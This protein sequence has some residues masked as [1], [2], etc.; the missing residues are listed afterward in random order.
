MFNVNEFELLREVFGKS[1]IGVSK[2]SA[3]TPI[4]EAFDEAYAT[5]IADADEKKSVSEIFGVPNQKCV[6]KIRDALGFRCIYFPL[7]ASRKNIIFIGPFYEGERNEAELLASFEKIG[8]KPQSQSFVMKYCRSIPNIR[9]DS[10]L[11]ILL[12][13]FIE[14]TFET[15]DYKIMDFDTHRKTDELVEMKVADDLEGSL[16]YMKMIEKRYKYENELIAAVTEG[17]IEK[18]SQIVSAFKST[19]FEMRSQD[20]IRNIKNYS[21]IMNTLLRKAAEQG[22][23]HPVYIDKTSGNFAVAIEG[24]KTAEGCADLMRQMFEK[25]CRLVKNHSLKGYSPLAQ[26]AISVIECDLSAD[27]SPSNIAAAAGVSLPYLC[28]VFKKETGKTLGDFIKDR[29]MA[30]AAKLLKET[31]LLVQT[32]ASYVGFEDVQYFS[33]T[34]KKHTGKTPLEYRREYAWQEKKR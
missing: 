31:A 5:V 15:P 9:Q 12:Y 34:F 23:V 10:E 17:R 19:N 16:L 21:I 6:Y 24:V 14:R 1:G 32:V 3:D 2:I 11:F 29:R 25:Y 27:L 4:A 26:K 13:S 7:N 28:S 22:G 20:P 33:K 30:H 8:I 18:V